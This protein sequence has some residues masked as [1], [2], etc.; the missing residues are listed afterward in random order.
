MSDERTFGL[1]EIAAAL[2]TT[3]S[4]LGRLCS[5]SE[6]GW[7]TDL[8]SEPVGSGQRQQW[9]DRQTV[10]IGVL[11]DLRRDP[12]CIGNHMKDRLI[13][14]FWDAEWGTNPVEVSTGRLWIGFDVDWDLPDRIENEQRE[15]EAIGS[16]EQ[17]QA[18]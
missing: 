11:D 6:K 8:R 1:A 4:M 9:N 13:E 3:R 17:E 7:G 2:G 16:T 5:D 10:L 15:Y 12:G 14:A 18:Q